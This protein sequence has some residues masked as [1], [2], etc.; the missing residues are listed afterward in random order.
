MRER[1]DLEWFFYIRKRYFYIRKNILFF[2]IEVL[3]IGLCDCFNGEEVFIGVGMVKGKDGGVLE[4]F[5]S[6]DGG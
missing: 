1:N 6:E 3:G 5:D 2:F 4:M